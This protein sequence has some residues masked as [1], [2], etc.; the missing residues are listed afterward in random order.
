MKVE[1]FCLK[2]SALNKETMCDPVIKHQTLNCTGNAHSPGD[3]VKNHDK[4]D[5]VTKF[6]GD[7]PNGIQTHFKCSISVNLGSISSYGSFSR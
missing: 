2:I 6:G 1:N 5:K 4:C 7:G 3:K